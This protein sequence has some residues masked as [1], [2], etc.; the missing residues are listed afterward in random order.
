MKW[1]VIDK[2]IRYHGFFKLTEIKLQHELYAGGQSPFLTREL[3]DRG[4]AVAVLPYDPVR[5]ELVLIEQF[6]IGAA[7]DKTGPWLIEIIA[8]YTEAGES[9]EDVVHREAYEEA[10]CRL[11]DIE[12]MYQFYSSPGGSSE[13]VQIFFARTD[14]A[15]IKGIHGLDDEGEDIRVHVISSQQVFDWLDNGKIDS[16]MPIIAIQW[17]RLNRDRI[18][19]KWL[20]S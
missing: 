13:Q 16:A 20:S 15:D 5:D 9:A 8:G 18:R 4:Q 11:T 2:K 7:E 6:R 19:E 10:G 12:S 1:S 14:S 17:F 3:I